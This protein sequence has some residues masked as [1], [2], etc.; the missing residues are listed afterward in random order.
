MKASNVGKMTGMSLIAGAVAFGLFWG[1]E[2]VEVEPPW[3][4]SLAVHGLSILLI[5]LGLINMQRKTE[6]SPAQR[7]VGWIAVTMTILGLLTILPLFLI[8]LA[9]LGILWVVSRNWVRGSAVTIGALVFLAAYL[10]GSRIGD[11][12]A[13]ELSDALS[14]VFA[15]ALVLIVGGLVATG[16]QQASD[17]HGATQ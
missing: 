10:F 5:S 15:S 16:L 14:A 9:C 8:G 11:E 7:T 6:A 2:L 3:M 4:L 12:G 17:R 1:R 13:R